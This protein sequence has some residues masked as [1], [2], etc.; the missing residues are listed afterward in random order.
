M[1]NTTDKSGSPKNITVSSFTSQF[2]DI[3]QLQT[4]LPATIPPGGCF[5]VRIRFISG[6][7][8]GVYNEVW[9]ILTND[10]CDPVKQISVTGEV[11]EVI[12]IY[13]GNSNSR[14]DSID[15][16]TIC[17]DFA[18]DPVNFNWA[19]L[20]EGEDISIENII[21]PPDVITLPYT[22]PIVLEPETGYLP[23]YFRFFPTKKG[24]FQDSIT[25]VV[26]SAECTI[27]R[28]IYVKGEGKAVEAEFSA[29]NISFGNVVVGQEGQM[30]VD[31][32]N[33]SD[34]SVR[35]SLYLKRGEAFFFTGARIVNIA[36]NS[37][38]TVPIIF[39][40]AEAKYYEDE[41]CFFDTDCYQSRCIPLDGTGVIDRFKFE[42][43][44]MET[45][46][47]IGCESVLDTID[48]INNLSVSQTL[49]DFV[50][51]DPSGKFSLVQPLQFPQ[52]ATLKAGETQR[53]I[54][55]Y[56]PNDVTT[57][58]ADRAFIR[59]KTADGEDWN[60]KLFG[61]SVTPSIFITDRTVYGTIE[62]GETKQ[63]T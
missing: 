15:F 48:I 18:S 35:L 23:E 62:V 31:I 36:P 6:D 9:E 59:Y 60:A 57:D 53:F 12:G 61:R 38:I 11:K 25:F 26:K 51:D 14:L 1:C 24:A 45:G 33:N 30:S 39:R 42:P 37:S 58:R 3:Y 29:P 17:V 56:T 63:K 21:L 19:N 16:G 32:I 2:P 27:M 44:I 20:L 22:F 28:K 43:I 49:S 55:R 10:A 8:S 40:P 13:A 54:L 41:L 52:T 5:D 7:T 4:A 34:Q 50:L 47:V 46:N